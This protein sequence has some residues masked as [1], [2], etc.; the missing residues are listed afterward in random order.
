MRTPAAI[1]LAICL[2]LALPDR[3]ASAQEKVAAKW[4]YAELSFRN[5]A[6][7]PAGKDQEGNEIP[8][9]PAT[10]A[11]QWTTGGEDVSVKGWDELAKK[12]KVEIKKDSSPVSQKIQVLNA[13]GAA[14]WELVDLQTAAPTAPAAPARGGDRGGPGGGGFGGQ[15]AGRGAQ[16]GVGAAQPSATPFRVNATNMLFKRRAQ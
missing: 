6:A 11:L 3:N 1:A 4:E 15:P 8:A 10:I 16:P 5:V 7:R 9:T 14:G 2:W 12:L 13:L